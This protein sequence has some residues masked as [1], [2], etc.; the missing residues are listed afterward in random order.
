VREVYAEQARALGRAL[1]A[2]GLELVFGGGH[3]GLM[4]VLADAVLEAGGRVVGVIPQALADRELAHDGLTQLHVV[5]TMHQRKALM[6]D[7]SDAFVALPGG[8]GTA[9]ELF[10]ILTWA[11]LGMHARPI[12]LLNTAGF[13]DPLLAWVEHMLR[14]GFLREQHRGLLL[15]EPAV[16]PLLDRLRQ[17]L[18][19]NVEKWID[20]DRR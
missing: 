10:E 18:P 15:V 13:F 6:A 5:E 1:A 2:R 20:P 4:G 11:Q 12:G 7:L 19:A 16:E 8:Y 14:E 9:D 17:P 3:I